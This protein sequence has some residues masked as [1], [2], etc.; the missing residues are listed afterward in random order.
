MAAS[1]SSVSTKLN[2]TMTDPEGRVLVVAKISDPRRHKPVSA[3]YKF[4]VDVLSAEARAS[5][6][7]DVATAK[8]SGESLNRNR[9]PSESCQFIVCR[10]A[11]S[12]GPATQASE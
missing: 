5:D 9:V 12:L 8:A 6:F 7:G 11:I 4:Q 10:P 3:V 1:N 2:A